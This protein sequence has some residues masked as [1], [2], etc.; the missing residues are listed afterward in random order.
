MKQVTLKSRFG[1]T[2]FTVRKRVTNPDGSYFFDKLRIDFELENDCREKVP[3]E[4]W[5]E[6]ENQWFDRDS[7]LKFKDA[8]LPL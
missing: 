5:E 4:S 2:G 8:F 1:P 6:V 3:V 7:N